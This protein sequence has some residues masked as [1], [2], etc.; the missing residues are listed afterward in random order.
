MVTYSE[1]SV[2]VNSGDIDRKE[3]GR[4]RTRRRRGIEKGRKWKTGKEERTGGKR[5]QKGGGEEEWRRRG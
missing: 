5:G 3:A 4:E 2:L 1:H